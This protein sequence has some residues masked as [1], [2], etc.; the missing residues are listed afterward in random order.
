MPM[1]ETYAQTAM[2]HDLL[3]GQIGRLDVEIPLDDLQVRRYAAEE[4]ECL[5]RRD[6]SQTQDL[7]DFSG[8]QEFFELWVLRRGLDGA[9]QQERARGGDE[10]NGN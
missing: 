8:G 7:A 6:V 4:L 5:F 2:R 9:R 1:R 10:A 3:E